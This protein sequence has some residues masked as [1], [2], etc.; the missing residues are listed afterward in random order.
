MLDV[1]SGAVDLLGI[2]ALMLTMACDHTAQGHRQVLQGTDLLQVF[3]RIDPDFC[4]CSDPGCR[5]E[6]HNIRKRRGLKQLCQKLPVIPLN[7]NPRKLYPNGK[8]ILAQVLEPWP[9]ELKVISETVL[10]V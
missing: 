5:G 8:N 4:G 9:G 3:P 10:E 2:R 7:I 6:E 1:C